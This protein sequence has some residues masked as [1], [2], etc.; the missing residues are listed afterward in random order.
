MIATRTEAGPSPGPGRRYHR[1]MEI[2]LAAAGDAEADPGHLQR[3][4]DGVDVHLRPRAPDPG[5]PAGLDRAPPGRP[6]GGRWPIEGPAGAETCVGFGSLSPFRD[7]AAYA[8]TVEDSVYVAAAQRGQGVGR[9]LLDELVAWPRVHGF[10]TVIARIVGDNEASIALHRACGFELV[11]VE[12]E[13]GRKTAGGSTW[14]SS[15]GCSEPRPAQLRR[16]PGR[17]PGRGLSSSRLLVVR[18]RRLAT[19]RPSGASQD[20]QQ[21]SRATATAQRVGVDELV[22]QGPAAGQPD[23]RRRPPTAR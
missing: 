10:H 16:R 2:R 5:R 18:A 7:R 21:T 23:E 22:E 8:T 4:G 11:G 6:P 1:P 13:V 14:S 9:V 3:R 19:T 17:R 15:S 20:A 12:R